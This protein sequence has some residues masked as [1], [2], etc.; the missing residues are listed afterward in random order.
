MAQVRFYGMQ[1]PFDI[2]R[3]WFNNLGC[4]AI[5]FQL[6]M[7][8]AEKWR[9][10]YVLIAYPVDAA[11]KIL[12]DKYILTV[13]KEI[14]YLAKGKLFL[15]NLPMS[16]TKIENFI[17]SDKVLK[18]DY[19]LFTPQTPDT[20]TEPKLKDY[21]SYN[22]VAKPDRIEILVDEDLNPSPPADP[23]V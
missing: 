14:K 18:I 5:I 20:S 21:V 6:E 12:A 9:D 8:D 4:Y 10:E 1:M 23:S 16:K 3:T 7:E 17:A 2:V 11:G 13:I 15:G 19:L 22:V